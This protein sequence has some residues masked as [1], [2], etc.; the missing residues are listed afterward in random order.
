MRVFVNKQRTK[1]VSNPFNNQPEFT[2]L[3][4][5]IHAF[6]NLK[7]DFEKNRIFKLNKL[8]IIK[9]KKHPSCTRKEIKNFNN[10]KRIILRTSN[11]AFLK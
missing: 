11:K 10:A 8:Y 2:A 3:Q 5:A 7:Q 9:I 1:T 4:G 6:P